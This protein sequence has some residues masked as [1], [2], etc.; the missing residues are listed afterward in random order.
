MRLALPCPDDTPKRIHPPPARTPAAICLGIALL[1]GAAVSASADTRPAPKVEASSKPQT[2][3]ASFY[4]TH[5]AGD[6]TASGVPF[7]P[8]KLTAASP[9]LPLGS[10]AKVTNK[11]TGQS[12]KVTVTDR[13]PHAKD[14]IL[15]VSPKAANRLG[16]TDDGVAPVKVEPLRTPKPAR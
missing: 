13:G 15:D 6:A 8:N 14:R 10:T 5:A 7:D 2:G 3:D 12:V 4:G 16:M 11:E 9:T 1:L